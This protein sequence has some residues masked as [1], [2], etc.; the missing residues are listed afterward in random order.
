VLL[1]GLTLLLGC[2]KDDFDLPQDNVQQPA[3]QIP[4]DMAALLSAEELNYL[5]TSFEQ[6]LIRHRDEDLVLPVMIQMD[7]YLSYPADRET[8]PGDGDVFVAIG[9]SG[10]WPE[11]ESVTYFEV[12][13][14][15]DPQ[16]FWVGEGS[17]RT[18]NAS[19][20]MYLFFTSEPDLGTSEGCIEQYVMSAK[21]NFNRG[22]GEFRGV[23][24]EALRKIFVDVDDYGKG[25]LIVC[26][27]VVLPAGASL[28]PYEVETE[29]GGAN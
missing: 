13:Y 7:V 19:S 26:G 29:N 4:T 27:H 5:E 11:M 18:M 9:G 25:I 16:G 22:S 23:S 1:A 8:G 15:P 20:P 28:A 3:L 2:E 21:L 14:Q 17:I 6:A 10:L 24:G 12:Q